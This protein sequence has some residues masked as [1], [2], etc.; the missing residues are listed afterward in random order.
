ML[1]RHTPRL[2]RALRF[3]RAQS[4]HSLPVSLSPSQRWERARTAWLSRGSLAAVPSPPTPA[5][6]VSHAV[7][8]AAVDAARVEYRRVTDAS[9]PL[10]IREH[11]VLAALRDPTRLV[12]FNRP[13]PLPALVD[14]MRLLWAEEALAAP[15]AAAPR[16][17]ARAH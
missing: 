9:K 11:N 10:R 4:S 12:E 15:R 16:A 5:D 14:I 17:P 8:A 6:D 1:P 3:L 13:M 7:A 2:T